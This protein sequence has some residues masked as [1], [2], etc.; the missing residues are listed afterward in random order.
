M[1]K[2]LS[3]VYNPETLIDF[4][5][6]GRFARTKNDILLGDVIPQKHSL[7]YL[8]PTFFNEL[9]DL[10]NKWAHFQ[11]IDKKTQYIRQVTIIY[12]VAKYLLKDDEIKCLAEKIIVSKGA[13]TRTPNRTSTRTRNSIAI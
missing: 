10:R 9:N 12:D 7:V 1:D 11:E 2:H 5:H 8:L 13:G 6:L 4:T 3:S